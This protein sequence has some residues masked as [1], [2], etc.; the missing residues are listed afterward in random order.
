MSVFVSCGEASGDRYL[1]DLAFRLSR[2]G[3]RLWGMGGPRCREAGVE[4]RWDMGELQVMGFTEALGALG[5]L[6]RLR[7]RIALEVAR[8]NPSCVVLTDSPD[9]H[10]PLA[11]RI[12]RE[13][14]RGPM[15]SLVP[16]AVWAWRSGRVRHLRELF[17]LCL[18]LFPFEH[19]F[20][21]DH[22]CRSAF[23]GHP[24][25]DRISQ[26]EL[27]PSCR[28]V[29]FMPGSRGGE[30][31]RHLPPFARA[32]ELLK[33]EGY[34]PVFSVASSLGEDVARW[35]GDL[36]GPL[37]VEVSRE[38]GVSLLARSVGAV[39]ASG[40]V[41]LEAMLVGR[42]GVVAYRTS[43]LSMALARLLVRSPHCALPNILLGR[44]LYPE[45]LQ[46][47]VRGDLLGRR[48][49][50]VL[51]QVEDPEGLR[52]WLSAFREGRTLLG[53]AGALDLWEEVVSEMASR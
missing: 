41:S 33:G 16:P 22:R 29:A 45:L 43:W 50:G 9:F 24:L 17:D 31:R 51:R 18:P 25:L 47:A 14:Y 26:A 15:V 35:M 13:G 38:D 19:R 2:R 5:R 53:R 4:T 12:R 3:F 30:V 44:E 23:V 39:M 20:L 34:R 32:A 8:A 42:P 21:Q 36:L 52:G 37:G 10:L 1:G 6:I 46:G 7:D 49:L 11:R 40:T 28:T 27:D 48:I